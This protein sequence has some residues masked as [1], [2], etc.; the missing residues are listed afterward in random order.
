M[1]T[2][3]APAAPDPTATATAQGNMNTNTAITQ[4]LLNQTNQVT[5]YGDLTYT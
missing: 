4:Q 3:S 2:P 5:P 1:N